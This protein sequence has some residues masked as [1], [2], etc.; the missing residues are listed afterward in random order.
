MREFEEEVV[1]VV[2]RAVSPPTHLRS[3]G[4]KVRSSLADHNSKPR[5]RDFKKVRAYLRCLPGL[6]AMYQEVAT[7]QHHHHVG[8]QHRKTH[9]SPQTKDPF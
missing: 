6:G 2:D 4:S 8:I 5:S 1:S 7:C 9:D 3:L